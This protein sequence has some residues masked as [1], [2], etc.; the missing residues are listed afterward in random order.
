MP[1]S[2]IISVVK[3]FTSHILSGYA[4]AVPV[5]CA[6]LLA[7]GSDVYAYIYILWCRIICLMR[8]RLCI[9]Y[10]FPYCGRECVC[11]E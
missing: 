5:P 6:L 9:C 4:A 7:F 2:S 10:V 11:I 8:A 3:C 1:C